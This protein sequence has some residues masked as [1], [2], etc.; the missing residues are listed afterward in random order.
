MLSRS[1][2]GRGQAREMP[3]LV[4][5]VLGL[6][7]HHSRVGFLAQLLRVLDEEVLVVLHPGQQRGYRVRI[8]G[9]ADNFQLHTLIADALIGEP[10]HGWLSGQPLDP[11]IVLAARDRPV[12]PEADVARGAFNLWTWQGLRPDG[13]LPDGMEASEFWIWNEGVPADIPPFEGVRTVLLGPEPYS[14]SWNAGRCFEGL[15]AELKVQEQLT[16]P[17]VC[18]RL[19]RIAAAVSQE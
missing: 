13:T 5:R 9:I 18:E 3:D 16:S 1:V 4:L 8:T 12:D 7:G 17:A 2:E 6:A 15:R 10:E 14:R 19:Q 11:R